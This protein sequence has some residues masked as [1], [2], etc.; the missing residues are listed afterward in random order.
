MQIHFTAGRKGFDGGDD[1]AVND[2]HERRER[3][4]EGRQTYFLDHTTEVR[5]LRCRSSNGHSDLG[6]DRSEGRVRDPADADRLTGDLSIRLQQR[7]WQWHR[8]EHDCEL[9]VDPE[10]PDDDL[11]PSLCGIPVEHCMAEDRD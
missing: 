5:K 1:L 11:E 3:V 8:Y 7:L 2:R 4:A 9:S 10:G 6:I